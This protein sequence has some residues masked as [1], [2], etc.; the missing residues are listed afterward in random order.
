MYEY[1]FYYYGAVL[2]YALLEGVVDIRNHWLYLLILSW[3]THCPLTPFPSRPQAI[4][5]IHKNIR[6]Q[7]V[8]YAAQASWSIIAQEST[9]T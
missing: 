4:R 5:D 9:P 2:A 7:Q 3:S 1:L 6:I 8:Y